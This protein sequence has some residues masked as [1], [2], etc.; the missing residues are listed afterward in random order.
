MEGEELYNVGKY[1]LDLPNVGRTTKY[2]GA[3]RCR[4]FNGWKIS[5]VQIQKT[6]RFS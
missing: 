3:S 4:K 2:L 1:I 5:K 6:N